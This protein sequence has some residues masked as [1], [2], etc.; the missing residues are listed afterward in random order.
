MA[1]PH[2]SG[3]AALILDLHPEFTHTKVKDRILNTIRPIDALNGKTVTGGVVNAY[4]ALAAGECGDGTVDAGE[5]CDVGAANGATTCGC[6]ADCTYASAGTSCA[7]GEFCNGEETCDGAG[8]CQAGT[9][10]CDDGVGCTDDSCDEVNDT[11]INAANDAYCP[12]DGQFCTG[13]EYCDTITDCDST[14]NP[15]QAEETCNDVNDTCDALACADITDK[16]TC[17]EDPNCEWVGHPR[18]GTCQDIVVC[19]PAPEL[20]GDGVDNDCD[21]LTDCADTADCG[22]DPAC[23]GKTCDTYPDRKSCQA[24]G[25][26]WSNKDKLCM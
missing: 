23:T 6:Q 10:E 9:A 8:A 14:G 19:D 20:C 26:T 13:I 25:C 5:D 17:N 7:D 21:G 22:D 4:A 1:A 3:V 2:V 24:A 18:N 12:D 15:C 11:C 16:G